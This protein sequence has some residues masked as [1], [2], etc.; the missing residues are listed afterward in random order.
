MR[1]MAGSLEAVD[2]CRK[3]EGKKSPKREHDPKNAQEERL[4]NACGPLF[5]RRAEAAAE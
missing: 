2:G 1:N 3:S 5:S 4:N